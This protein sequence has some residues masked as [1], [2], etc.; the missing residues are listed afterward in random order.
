MLVEFVHDF[1]LIE[2]EQTPVK[3]NTLMHTFA[4][5]KAA[6]E[7]AQVA[8]HTQ[9][10]AAASSLPVPPS[11]PARPSLLELTA[12]SHTQPPSKKLLTWRW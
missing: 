10:Q 1:R 4:A 9:A 12:E 7:L 6:A 11:P 2:L 8:A 3:S 5:Q